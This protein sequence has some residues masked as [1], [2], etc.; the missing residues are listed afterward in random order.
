MAVH[1]SLVSLL[2]FPSLLMFL[3]SNLHSSSINA[4]SLILPYLLLQ[5]FKMSPLN[6]YV[7]VE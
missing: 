4:K 3:R 1:F 5:F 6:I 7:N 2:S